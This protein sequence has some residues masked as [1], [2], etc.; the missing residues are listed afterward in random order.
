ML[1]RKCR[2]DRN[3]QDLLAALHSDGVFLGIIAVLN[4]AEPDQVL[5][6]GWAASDIQISRRRHQHAGHGSDPADQPFAGACYPSPDSHVDFLCIEIEQ[7][8][9]GQHI[10]PK[11]WVAAPHIGQERPHEGLTKQHVDGHPKSAA[12]LSAHRLQGNLHLGQGRED[13]GGMREC[14]LPGRGR[15]NALA[16]PDQKLLP[17]ARFETSQFLAD[18]RLRHRKTSSRRRYGTGLDSGHQG[19]KGCYIHNA[20]LC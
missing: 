10:D 19:P 3:A 13:P 12:D 1:C 2:C 11:R 4:I 15:N 17:E 5:G 18:G 16:G 20:Y 8:V 14:N 9:R 7:G 6:T